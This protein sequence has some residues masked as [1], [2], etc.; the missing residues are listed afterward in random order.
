MGRMRVFQSSDSTLYSHLD[1]GRMLKSKG[2]QYG[3]CRVYS[4][5]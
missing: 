1:N 3:L 4:W 2:L 5:A